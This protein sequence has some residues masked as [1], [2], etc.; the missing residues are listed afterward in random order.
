MIDVAAI[1]AKHNIVAAKFAIKAT[2]SAR[3]L[4]FLFLPLTKLFF[5]GPATDGR[6]GGR[7]GPS[8]IAELDEGPDGRTPYYLSAK[9][10]PAIHP[11]LIWPEPLAHI[12][13]LAKSHPRL[14][15]W[16]VVSRLY[17][18]EMIGEG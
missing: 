5:A 11:G 6:R 13:R 3:A 2:P 7:G 4:A 8:I 15:K 10:E 9:S 14:C 12:K 1:T 17:R 18:H 16:G